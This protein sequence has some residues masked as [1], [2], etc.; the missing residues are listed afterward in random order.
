VFQGGDN[1]GV[2]TIFNEGTELK[3]LLYIAL[4]GSRGAL[5][6]AIILNPKPVV[7]GPRPPAAV[8][9]VANA[10]SEG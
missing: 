7:S 10:G 6:V 4:S 5:R 3:P 8:G 1:F 9:L 2:G